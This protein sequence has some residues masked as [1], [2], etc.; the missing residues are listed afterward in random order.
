MEYSKIFFDMD[1]V[2]A[3]FDRGVAEL[4]G[5]EPHEQGT[6]SAEYEDELYDRMSRYGH[7][8]EDLQP[9]PGALDMFRHLYERYPDRC[10]ILS[11]IPKPSRGVVYAGEDKRR[12]IE[13]YFGPEV[14]V[15]IVLRKE[16]PLYCTGPE[17]ILIDD[18]A[19]NITEWETAGGTGILHTGAEETLERLKQLGL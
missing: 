13:R 10:A 17:C 4:L 1:G 14:Q 3:D 12:W 16:K 7:F 9:L 11:G 18:Y 15:N 8:Y 5:L 19:R 2:L 6:S